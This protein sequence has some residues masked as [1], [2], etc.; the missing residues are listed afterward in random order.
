MCHFKCSSKHDFSANHWQFPRPFETFENSGTPTLRRGPIFMTLVT[1]LGGTI[2]KLK[3]RYLGLDTICVK[4][5][6][7]LHYIKNLSYVWRTFT[8]RHK[9]SSL[10]IFLT[11]DIH[12]SSCQHI[13]RVIR[14]CLFRL[15]NHQIISLARGGEE[16]SVNS[17]I[18]PSAFL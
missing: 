11:N 9:F 5:I 13:P 10:S 1:S 2:S 15:E 16:G 18:N 17:G 12:H 8:P 14:Q 3:L 7:P 4:I 6:N